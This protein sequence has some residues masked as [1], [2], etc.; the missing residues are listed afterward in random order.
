M[1][2]IFPEFTV[3][4][5]WVI[6][7]LKNKTNVIYWFLFVWNIFLEQLVSGMLETKGLENLNAITIKFISNSTQPFYHL[8]FYNIFLSI[9]AVTLHIKQH[10]VCTK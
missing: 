5:I 9:L 1:H 6:Y 3:S 4:G 8:K 2:T 7:V 10:N